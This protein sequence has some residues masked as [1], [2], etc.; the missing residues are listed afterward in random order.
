[1]S[2]YSGFIKPFLKQTVGTIASPTID[3][4]G[5]PTYTT[6]ATNVKCR[7]TYKPSIVFSPTGVQEIAKAQLWTFSD[8]NINELFK[9][10]FQGEHFEVV[11]VDKKVGLDG[12]T[13]FLKCYLR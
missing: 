4:N 7:F 6:V 11:E 13:Y 10:V 3:Y 5:D 9:V 12:N 2:S 8:T 1:M